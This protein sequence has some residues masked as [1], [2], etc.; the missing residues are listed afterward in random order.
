MILSLDAQGIATMNFDQTFRPQIDDLLLVLDEAIND[1]DVKGLLLVASDSNFIADEK[2]IDEDNVAKLFARMLERHRVLRRLETCGKPVAIALSGGAVGVS[3]ELAM[4]THYRVAS[5][6]VAAQFGISP[7]S[8][9]RMPGSGGTQRLPRLIGI[10]NAFSMLLDNK[11]ISVAEAL[12]Q[13]LVHA[14]APAGSESNEARLWLLSKLVQASVVQ[15]SWDVKGYKVPGGAVS[16]PAIQQLLMITNAM[17]RARS[18]AHNH[19]LD[20]ASVNTLS[21]VYEGLMTDIDT[22]LKTEA[23]YFVNAIT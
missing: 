5:D 7:N 20:K 19:V 8:P 15:Q 12:A 1:D 17:L 13:Q 21:S 18:H 10:Q 22:G 14:L 23:R 11:K 6:V 16:S 4:V 2:N 3:L 9:G